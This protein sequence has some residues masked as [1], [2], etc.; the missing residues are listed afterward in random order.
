MY[1]MTAVWTKAINW[2]LNGLVKCILTHLTKY[3]IKATTRW[4][5][6]TFLHSRYDGVCFRSVWSRFFLFICSLPQSK[7][8]NVWNIQFVSQV[9]IV[10]VIITCGVAIFKNIILSH[11]HNK[12]QDIHYNQSGRRWVCEIRHADYIFHLKYIHT[13]YKK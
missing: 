5:S 7:V 10:T 3:N 8:L 2:T 13:G 9:Y 4:N 1:L 12:F 11:V 6:F